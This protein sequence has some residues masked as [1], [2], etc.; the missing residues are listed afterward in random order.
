MGARGS[1]GLQKQGCVLDSL[2]P[3]S[4]L[5]VRPPVRPEAVRYGDTPGPE[6]LGTP[7]KSDHRG[8]RRA[9]VASSFSTHSCVLLPHPH[10]AATEYSASLAIY[11]PHFT[12]WDTEVQKG[13]GTC[14]RGTQQTPVAEGEKEFGVTHKGLGAGRKCLEVFSVGIWLSVLS[15]R[16]EEPSLGTAGEPCSSLTGQ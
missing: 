16:Q 3:P 1:K 9:E 8:A 15:G 7:H 6:K 10:T 13:K 12:D 5:W 4:L 11:L 2:A 14:S